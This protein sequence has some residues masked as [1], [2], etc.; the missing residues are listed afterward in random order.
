[1]ERA[2]MQENGSRHNAKGK[3]Q[4]EKAKRKR[5]ACDYVVTS[6]TVV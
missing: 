2:K 4:T 5:D 6:G 1:M 3:Q